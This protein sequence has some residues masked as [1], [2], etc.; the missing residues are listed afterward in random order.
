MKLSVIIPCFNEQDNIEL[1]YNKFSKIFQEQKGNY[2]LIFVDDG[3]KDKTLNNIKN[4]CKKDKA[5]KGLS[6]SRN[7]GKESAMYAGL[8]ESKGEYVAFIDAD[9]QQNPEILLK[10]MKILD[11]N[12]EYDIVT[13]FQKKR[14][15][16]V[17]LKLC[18][19]A[20][21]YIINA[22]SETEFK[23]NASD[24][25]MMRRK[26]AN[27]IID[28]PEYYRFLKGIFSW[29]GFNNYYIEYEVEK[30]ATGTTKW[31]FRKLFVYAKEGILAYTTMPLKLPIVFG[32]LG[33]LA[34]IV[35]L[36]ITIISYSSLNV[37]ITIML[38]LFGIQFI[39]MGI[40]GEYLAHD[41]I[42]NK[43]RPIYILKEK[44]GDSKNEN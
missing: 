20:F 2:E 29:I 38:F 4:I 15:D 35:M 14:K 13:A 5:V 16:G 22:I 17:I 33:I 19:K 23:D 40:M 28:I 9:L 43:H 37:I 1:M 25:R 21:N 41:Y 3:S 24:F 30:R 34:S 26:V 18:K 11:E 6:F 44:I 39:F 31:S 10:M 36:I 32:I 27:A 7:F 12:E 8:K 42:E